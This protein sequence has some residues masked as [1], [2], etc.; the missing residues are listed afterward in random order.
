MSFGA[1]VAAD[2]ASMAPTGAPFG[3][4]SMGEIKVRNIRV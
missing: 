3:N 4:L 2:V 1:P